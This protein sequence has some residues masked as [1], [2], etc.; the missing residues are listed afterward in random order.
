VRTANCWCCARD[1]GRSSVV[2]L[3]GEITN[4]HELRR[5]RAGVVSVM[6]KARQRV[7]Q[8]WIVKAS[9]PKPLLKCRNAVED[10][11]TGMGK[12]SREKSERYLLT[13]LAASGMKRA[14]AR[15]RLLYGRGEPVV[16]ES[17]PECGW[18][19]GRPPSGR[20]REELST[21]PEHR[22]GPSCSS[23]EAPVMGVE[24][25]GRVIPVHV[26]INHLVGGIDG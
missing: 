11:K 15:S 8:V 24:R 19:G 6:E 16:L 1:G 3:Q 12:R 23:E 17:T 7:R 20:N 26:W 9:E 21:G 5:L 22:G 13:A 25:R 4:H 14:R 18:G 10:V 2:A